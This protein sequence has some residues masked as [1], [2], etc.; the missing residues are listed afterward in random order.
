MKSLLKI[1]LGL[2]VII[3]LL[4]V[5]AGFLLPVIYDKEDLKAAIASR[6][7]EQTGRELQIDGELD[8]SVFPW[9]AVEVN[10]LSLG[11][12]PG[13]GDQPQARI[14]RARAGVAL[15]PLFRK[16][17]SVDEITLDGLN[18][19]L[20]VNA[21]GQ[22]NWDD[23][24]AGGAAEDAP[25]SETG[26]FSSG[27]VA[28]VNVRDAFVE[29]NDIKAGT[30]YRLSDFSLQTGALGDGKAVPLKLE[31]LLENV[32]TE[33]RARVELAATTAVDLE[34]ERYSLSDFELA[35]ALEAADQSQTVRILAPQVE[36]DLAAQTLQ[37]QTYAIELAD[38]RARGG[39]TA[40]NIMDDPKFAGTLDA[41]E[42]SPAKL[43]RA[44]N[45]EAPET[46]DPEVLQR[47]SVSTRFAGDSR[48]LVLEDMTLQLD[49]S[50]LTGG[51]S[52]RNFDNPRI[53]FTLG[54]DEID[55][56]R[57]LAPA[58]TASTSDDIVMPQ[59]ELQGHDV[60]GQLKAGVLHLAGLTFNDAEVSVAISNGKLRLNPLTAGFYGGRYSGDIALDGSGADPVITLDEKID[61]ITFQ[62]LV[63]DLVETE[64]LSGTAQGHV[65]LTGR[66]KTSNEVLG[67]LHGD[68]GLTLTEGALEGI[69]IWYEIRR[70]L[71][72]YKGLP[73]P[74]PEPAR[75]V[76][77]RMKL[78]GTVKDGVVNAS[79]LTGE[80]PFLTVRGN[81][82]VNLVQSEVNLGLVAEVRSS[83]ELAGDPLG[84]ELRG[85]K[86]P[87]RVSGPLDAPAL[88][89]DWEALLK[90]E[91]TDLLLDK[92]GLGQKKS[93]AEGAG[94]AAEEE[95]QK[96]ALEETAKGALF[97]LL[98]GKDK[99]KDKDD[100][101]G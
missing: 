24:A 91:A 72:L 94:D 70:G 39:L 86:L 57:Y 50:R 15:V 60:Q 95:P 76:F 7:H 11:N 68:L 25:S 9:L 49:Q 35:L 46:S 93:Q 27:R 16:Q 32:A 61:S 64:S 1:V 29:Y 31:A 36:M 47:A 98:R 73:A 21:K 96:D 58:D 17:I 92:L 90:G 18:L 66:G 88:S 13:F 20:A 26:M 100:G 51:L 43:M 89:L 10:D 69:N 2:A 71:A 22:N 83:P 44:L 78:A 3:V 37:L 79:E 85:K 33:T 59:Q 53:G 77:S 84:S 14:G 75:T 40:S 19:V 28:G 4:L 87:F 23:L 82:A 38:L 101:G 56:D 6:V 45:M 54:V 42:F 34:A 80:L 55:L 74:E 97:D 63:A 48:Q 67:N 62:R 5:L 30:H 8:F 41:A 99:D 52:V 12:A 81:G 65:R